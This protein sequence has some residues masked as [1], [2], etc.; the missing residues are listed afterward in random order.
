MTSKLWNTYHSPEHVKPAL[1][2][3]L[4]DLGLDY[5]DSFLIHFPIAL[6]FVPFEERYPPEWVHDPKAQSPA[7]KLAAVPLSDTWHAMEE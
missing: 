6:A 4:N 2:K 3:I 7:M 5:L 1:D